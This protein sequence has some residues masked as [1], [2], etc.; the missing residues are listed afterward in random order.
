VTSEL[1]SDNCVYYSTVNV[2][3]APYIIMDAK[4]MGVIIYYGLEQNERS[5]RISIHWV[6]VI[7]KVGIMGFA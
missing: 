7:V 1:D 2:P 6:A 3:W 5:G 4:I